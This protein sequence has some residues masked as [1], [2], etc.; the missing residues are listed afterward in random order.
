M[1]TALEGVRGQCHAPAALYPRERPGTHCTGSWVGPRAGL[2]RCGKSRPPTRIRS[3]DR[4]ARSHSLYRLRYPAYSYILR[5]PGNWIK[6]QWLCLI[7]RV[8]EQDR[9]WK[10]DVTLRRIRAAGVV[11]EDSTYHLFCVCV[12]VALGVQH[13]M[14]LHHID[15][16]ALPGSTICFHVIF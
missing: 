6:L 3:P 9:Q 5:I 13:A 2:D 1:A 12:F 8:G 4:P 16:C 10:Y 11:V 15:V 14:R 7:Y